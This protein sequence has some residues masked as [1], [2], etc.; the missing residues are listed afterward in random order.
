MNPQQQQLPLHNTLLLVQLHVSTIL[1]KLL[2]Q[3]LKDEQNETQRS[4]DLALEQN[5]GE[6]QTE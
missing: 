4:S 1:R 3:L 5:L 2:L 6:S